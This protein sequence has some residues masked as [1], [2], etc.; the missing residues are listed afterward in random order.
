MLLPSMWLK[1]WVTKVRTSKIVTFLLFLTQNGQKS[2]PNFLQ[3]CY[4]IVFNFHSGFSVITLCK[5]I[6]HAKYEKKP[7]KYQFLCFFQNS[8][9]KFCPKDHTHSENEKGSVWTTPKMK[10]KFFLVE[11]TK[12]DHQFSENFYFIKIS[13]MNMFWLSYELFYIFSDVFCQKSAIAS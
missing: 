3:I 6:P 12:A 7:L 13:Y 10:K 5:C 11:I 4:Y 2:C 8:G 1:D 9:P